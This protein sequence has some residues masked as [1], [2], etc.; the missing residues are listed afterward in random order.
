MVD[1]SDRGIVYAMTA[2]IVLRTKH[3]NNVEQ[4]LMLTSIPVKTGPSISREFQIHGMTRIDIALPGS[5]G[6]VKRACCLAS[7]F[8]L[9]LKAKLA[10]VCVFPHYLTEHPEV[11][12]CY[13]RFQ[14][15]LV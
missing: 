8:H 14:F 3:R 13:I 9:I 7:L 5:K 1:R 10:Q 6:D 4:L 2:L 15:S 11:I 12:L